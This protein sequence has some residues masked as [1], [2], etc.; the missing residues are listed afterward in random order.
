[1]IIS[2]YGE[3]CFKIQSGD[4]TILTDPL[5]KESG[6]D[7]PRFKSDLVLK[8]LAS[9]PPEGENSHELV[10]PGEYNFKI[11]DKEVDVEGFFLNTESTDKFIKTVYLVGLEDLKLCFLGHLSGGLPSEISE[12][13][14]E[15]DI[16]F[17]PAGGAPFIDQKKA[18][19]LIKQIEP[20]IVVPGFYKM[21]N[22]KRLAED[23]KKFLK[24][25][26]HDSV[27]EE[28]L[29]IKKKDVLIIKGTKIV[30]LKA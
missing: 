14:E 15:I 27:C 18:A 28:K 6:L 26:D 22:L 2:F 3:G 5:N 8:T 19:V 12:R 1:M 10:G 11:A 4:L 9:F 7:V 23:L 25:F 30:C 17:I 20:K 13:L 24:E 21:P 29:V 16:L